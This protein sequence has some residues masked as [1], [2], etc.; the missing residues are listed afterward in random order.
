MIKSIYLGIWFQRTS[1]HLR[2]IYRF[3]KDKQSNKHLDDSVTFGYWKRMNIENVEYMEDEEIDYVKASSG[4]INIRVSEDGV[5]ILETQP[6]IDL[7]ESI[8]VLENYYSEAFGPALSFLFSK[9][10]PLPKKLSEIKEAYPINI[11]CIGE[12]NES[13]VSILEGLGE[14]N[15]SQVRNKQL[16]IYNSNRV[17]IINVKQKSVLSYIISSIDNLIFFREFERQLNNYLGVHRKLWEEVS[18]IRDSKTLLFKEF[19]S[20]RERLLE[21]AETLLFVKARLLQMQDILV[22]RSRVFNFTKS[23]IIFKNLGINRFEM[24]KSSQKYILHLW[25]MTIE[26]TNSTL[27]LLDSLYQENTQRELTALR[28]I[29]LVGVLTGFFGMNIIF[30]WQQNW[31][32]HFLYSAVVTIIIAVVCFGGYYLFKMFLENRKFHIRK[33][34]LPEKY[35]D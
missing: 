11:L 8:S 31:E 9:G 27:K 30:P 19:G 25:Q 24:L 29:T 14:A 13:C 4:K 18:D 28:M 17:S 7:K 35:Q 26:Y 10:A 3:L 33:I 6:N 1:L 16:E 2:E 12:T 5:I 22:A 21:Y 32:T 34:E 23:A 15:Y 20:F